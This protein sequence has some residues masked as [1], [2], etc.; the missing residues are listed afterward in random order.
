M[1]DLKIGVE[2]SYMKEELDGIRMV[3]SQGKLEFDICSTG[4]FYTS[5]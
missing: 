2:D 3:D 1:L 4:I 5:G